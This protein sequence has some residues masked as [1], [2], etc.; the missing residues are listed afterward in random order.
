MFLAWIRRWCSW[1]PP[2]RFQTDSVIICQIFPKEL[3]QAERLFLKITRLKSTKRTFSLI[4]FSG[5]S[6]V[7]AESLQSVCESKGLPKFGTRNKHQISRVDIY[8]WNFTRYW[9]CHFWYIIIRNRSS[10]TRRR[11]IVTYQ[12]SSTSWASTPRQVGLSLHLTLSCIW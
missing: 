8:R 7:L 2:D 4:Q 12:I 1:S 11:R 5:T 9:I 10:S 6:R 3:I